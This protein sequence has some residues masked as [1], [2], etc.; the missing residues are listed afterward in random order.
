MPSKSSIFNFQFS[1]NVI[2]A[3]LLI[4]SNYIVKISP[5]KSIILCLNPF[6]LIV[7]CAINILLFIFYLIF[8][9]KYCLIP[10]LA[11]IMN[12]NS[13]N[14]IFPISS[15]LNFSNQN[16]NV[17]VMTYN[18]MVFGLYN[19][20][21]NTEVKQNILKTINEESP[22]ILCLQEVYWNTNNKNFIT[23][24]SVLLILNTKE[25]HKF[26]ITSPIKGQN[27][28]LATASKYPIVGEYSHK[29]DNSYNGFIYSDI[30]INTDTV[31]VYN[32]HLQ[33]IQFDQNDY[34]LIENQSDLKIDTLFR[35]IIKK[36]AKAQQKRASQA[37]MVRKSIDSCRYPV[38]VCGDFNDL[39]LTY[40]YSTIAQNLKDSFVKKGKFGDNT[41]NR[42]KIP[43]RIDYILF[44]DNFRAT[45]HKVIENYNSDHFPVVTEF[46]IMK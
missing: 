19:W 36:Y 15:Y 34:T 33:S 17:K 12:Y 2:F 39:P 24:D 46:L 13:I 38:F 9:F 1:I 35:T 18:V 4:F 41:W 20:K 6:V 5:E 23:L 40:T 25:I 28:G 37:E 32:C 3:I 30:I 27:F 14:L 42:F 45:S 8:K 22:D 26:S 11:L 7:I 16:G 31:R 44:S 43:Q 10:L 21:N 29:F